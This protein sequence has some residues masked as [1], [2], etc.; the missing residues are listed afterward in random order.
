MIA[1][2]GPANADAMTIMFKDEEEHSAQT[3]ASKV[4]PHMCYPVSSISKKT[5]DGYVSQRL[6]PYTVDG[7]PNE[8]MQQP[9]DYFW[10]IK[11]YRPNDI[12]GVPFELRW[13][14]YLLKAAYVGNVQQP[15][16]NKLMEVTIAIQDMLS[17]KG[18][19]RRTQSNELRNTYAAFRRSQ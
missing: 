19:E 2:G 5:K 4:P 15:I 17:D 16:M 7:P 14:K 8:L 6:V 9:G 12:I 1:N 10:D 13:E 3:K 18:C 11:M